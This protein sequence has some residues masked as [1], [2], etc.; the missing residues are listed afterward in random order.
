MEIYPQGFEYYPH[1][2]ER[3]KG[4]A[5]FSRRGPSVHKVREGL[6]AKSNAAV[7]LRSR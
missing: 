2:Q 5:E 4:K 3:L 7:E 1:R 6:V